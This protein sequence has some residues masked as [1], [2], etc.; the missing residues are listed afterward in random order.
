MLQT[1][2]LSIIQKREELK[3]LKNSLQSQLKADPQYSQML[4]DRRLDNEASKSYREKLI[5]DSPAL[6]DAWRRAE[7]LKDEIASLNHE[8]EG[9]VIPSIK[10]TDGQMSLFENLD[11]RVSVK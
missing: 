6:S 3:V 2:I 8:L 4:E 7:A 1:V 11:I 10:P 9:L 5:G